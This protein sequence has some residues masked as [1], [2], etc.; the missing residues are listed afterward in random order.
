MGAELTDGLADG[1]LGDAV[2]IQEGAFAGDGVV[3]EDDSGAD[4]GGE[5]VGDLLV[6]GREVVG[7]GGA[8]KAD[9]AAFAGDGVVQAAV[10][11]LTVEWVSSGETSA[12]IRSSSRDALDTLAYQ[13]VNHNNEMTSLQ[14]RDLISGALAEY[15]K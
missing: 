13:Q 6:D 4:L 15:K 5:I 14:T 7:A 2:P 12:V 8:G 11:Q 1:G 10:A 3:C 9:V